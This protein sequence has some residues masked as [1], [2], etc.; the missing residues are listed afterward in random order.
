MGGIELMKKHRIAVVGLGKRG[1]TWSKNIMERSDAEL[2]AVCDE[3]EDRV[4]KVVDI[5]K[6]KGH[7]ETLKYAVTDYHELLD[8]EDIEIVVIVVSWEKHVP[9]SVEFMEAG[10][11]TALEVGGA[12]SL[13]DCY[14][15]VNA[16]ERT[17]TPF[18]LWRIAAM[19]SEN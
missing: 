3:Y 16:Y 19:V 17:N 8:K 6:E 9:I 2:V 13:Q 18:S 12:Y 7:A 11:I 1:Q 4:Q 14:S 15:L 10:I 5:A